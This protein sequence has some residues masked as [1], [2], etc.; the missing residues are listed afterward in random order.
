MDLCKKSV[1]YVEEEFKAFLTT[2]CS[3][4]LRSHVSRGVLLT[5]PYVHPPPYF[6]ISSGLGFPFST[7][8]S[9]I[10]NFLV[11]LILSATGVETGLAVSGLFSKKLLTSII[12]T[13]IR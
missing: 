1:L 8:S 10:P 13:N 7:S 5:T 2:L 6:L 11:L 12:F 3:P 9:N 4:F